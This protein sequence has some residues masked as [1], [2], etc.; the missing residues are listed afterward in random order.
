LIRD[1]RAKGAFIAG[2]PV[3][4]NATLIL[5]NNSYK[6]HDFTI[7]F[8]DSIY[9][10]APKYTEKIKNGQIDLTYA[11][12]TTAIGEA[13]ISYLMPGGK[14]IELIYFPPKE[15]P[16]RLLD[17]T[18]ESVDI[19][20]DILYRGVVGFNTTKPTEPMLVEAHIKKREIPAII[21]SSPRQN[22]YNLEWD[23]T[24]TGNY[25]SIGQELNVASLETRLQIQNNN[26]ML[27]LNYAI[28]ALTCITIVFMLLQIL[29][30][31]S[32]K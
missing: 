13:N 24:T 15:R 7:V 29:L 20:N 16:K 14:N 32:K 6:G 22:N 27:T 1:Y 23:G 12:D 5:N 21:Y 25:I 11:N 30:R 4:V 18:R 19:V 26:I 2:E 10:P 28:A 17:Q 9:Y 8:P 31:N 3:H